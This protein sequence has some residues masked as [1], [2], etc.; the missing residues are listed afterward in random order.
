MYIDPAERIGADAD[1]CWWVVD[2]EVGLALD[3]ALAVFVPQWLADAWPFTAPRFMGRGLGWEQ[4]LALPEN[5]ST[6]G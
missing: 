4:W 3:A 2:D 5:G 1:I 6:D